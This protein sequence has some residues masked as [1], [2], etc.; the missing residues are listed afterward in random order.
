MQYQ[1]ALNIPFNYRDIASACGARWDPNHRVYLWTGNPNQLPDRLKPFR[2]ER[3]SWTDH[4]ERELNELEVPQQAGKLTLKPRAHQEQAIQWIQDAYHAKAPGFLLADDMGLG[5]TLVAWEGLR[6]CLPPGSQVGI[7]TPFSVI[8]NWQETLAD[9]GNHD[10]EIILIN[11]DRLR[12]FFEVDEK[13]NKGKKS[14]V[15]KGR[16]LKGVARFGE[17][18]APDALIFDE[19]HYLINPQSARAKFAFRLYEESAFTIWL[20]GTPGQSPLEL[21]YL[22]PLLRY[23]TEGNSNGPCTP[24]AL[25]NWATHAGIHLKRGAFG[26]WEWE[27]GQ[28]ENKKV[29]GIL[30]TSHTNNNKAACR[31]TSNEIAGWPELQRILEPIAL[32]EDQKAQYQASWEALRHAVLNT[33]AQRRHEPASIAMV[34]LLRFRQKASLLRID[35]TVELAQTSLDAG[36]RVAISCEFLDTIRALET[37]FEKSKITTTTITGELHSAND[38]NLAIRKFNDGHAQVALFT[39]CEGINL[40]EGTTH[41]PDQPRVQIDHDIKWSGIKMD[42]VDHRCHRN[43]KF[44][45]VIW[46]FAQGTQEVKVA[47]R[48]L[49]RL[50]A[51]QT[52]G[53]A[54]DDNRLIKDIQDAFWNEVEKTK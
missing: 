26:K 39:V 40:Q 53:G 36:Y 6:R 24:E 31:R 54:N 42:Q 48:V 23:K 27:A 10:L 49:Q 17:M 34:E 9:R 4:V 5:K 29:A 21:A 45:K 11:Y 46:T 41:E 33:P 52:L 44:A 15:K 43:G 20:S 22:L 19:S 13:T 35:Q 18:R 37:A 30:Y 14:K 2:P 3:W 47:E 25:E 16:T 12:V 38:R 32:D 51:I 8:G 50:Q 7:I 28:G 1:N